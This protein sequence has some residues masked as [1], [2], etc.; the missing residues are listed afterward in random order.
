MLPTLALSLLA[1]LLLAG[2]PTGA[3]RVDHGPAAA[4]LRLTSFTTERVAMG[5]RGTFTA[6]ELMYRTSADEQLDL[7]FRFRGTGEVALQDITSVVL[8]TSRGG[9]SRWTASPQGGCRLKLR[10]ASET[11]IVGRLACPRPES[12][13]PFEIAFDAKP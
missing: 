9:L 12:G 10:R 6:A 2:L 11:E 7:R 5:K 13:Q 4:N 8:R 1:P 3:A